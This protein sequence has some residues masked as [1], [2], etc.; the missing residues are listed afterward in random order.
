M[1]HKISIVGNLGQDPEMR[2]TPKG[3]AVTNFSVAANR[4]WTNEDGSP[5]E[6]TVWF[7]VTVW[8]KLAE[9]CNQYLSKGRQVFVEGRMNPDKDTGG[10]RIWTG[11]DGQPRASFEVVA[12]T[13]KF[14]GKDGRDKDAAEPP[15]TMEES[16][17][18]F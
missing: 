3:Q 7:R 1:Y 14:L 17:I 8:G 6:E 15:G 9:V 16:D 4:K 11:N 5:G 12:E 2:F 13:V 10:P 18:P